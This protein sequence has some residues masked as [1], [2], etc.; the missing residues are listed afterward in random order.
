M[1]I[2]QL[3]DN[4]KETTNLSIILKHLHYNVVT[5]YK[6]DNISI[7]SYDAFIVTIDFFGNNY[8]KNKSFFED[9]KKR[10]NFIEKCLTFLS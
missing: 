5:K 6:L 1:N 3:C 2:L 9:L 7:V 4:Y 10:K 8:E